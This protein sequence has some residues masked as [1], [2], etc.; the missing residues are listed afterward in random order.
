LEDRR[1]LRLKIVIDSIPEHLDPE[2]P[3]DLAV[4]E[5]NLHVDD[6]RNTVTCDLGHLAPNPDAPT[7]RNSIRDPGHVHRQRFAPSG[8]AIFL[9][10]I[11]TGGGWFCLVQKRSW[12][13]QQF[14]DPQLLGRPGQLDIGNP[15]DLRRVNVLHRIC[16]SRISKFTL[17]AGH[18]SLNLFSTR[19][20]ES[21]ASTELF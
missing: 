9:G 3:R 8:T 20:L 1:R 7:Y 17:P 11:L 14:L 6:V 2:G 18:F 19:R 21:Q 13:N 4:I 15:L 16:L 5:L 10:F 12:C